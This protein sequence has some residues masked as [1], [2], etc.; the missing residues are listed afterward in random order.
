MRQSDEQF[1]NILDWF[2]IATQLQL[3]VD[4][5]NNRCFCTPANDPKF[6]HLFYMNETKQKHNELGF[7]WSEMDVFILH[8]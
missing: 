8:A 4:T 5:I 1:I 2:W 6:P 7:L 3:D